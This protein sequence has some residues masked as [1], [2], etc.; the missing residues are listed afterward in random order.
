MFC[1]NCGKEIPEEGEFC[2]QCGISTEESRKLFKARLEEAAPAAPSPSIDFPPPGQSASA[3]YA[4]IQTKQMETLPGQSSG[5][6]SEAPPPSPH[7]APKP[8]TF[9]VPPSGQPS[10]QVSETPPP[11]PFGAPPSPNGT[12][13]SPYDAPQPAPIGAAP[14]M[15]MGAAPTMPMSTAPSGP[16]VPVPPQNG[17]PPYPPQ[18]M[19]AP[20][21]PKKKSKK[22]IFI[23]I[24]SVVLVALIVVGVIVGINIYRSNSYDNAVAMLESG[25][26]QGAYDAFGKLGDYEDSADLQALAQR[27]MDY[28]AAVALF[29]A[30]D[31]E[32][33][34]TAFNNLGSFEDS[35]DYVELCTL[36][37]DYKAAVATYNRGDYETALNMFKSLS[38]KNFLDSSNWVDKSKYAIATEKYESG[39]LYGAYKD[40]KALGSFD[41]S[42]E[43]MEKCTTPYP[44]T[45]ELYHNPS[46][47]S[48]RSAI[49]LD[50]SNLSRVSYYKVY[51]GDTLVSTI[52][53]NPGG[54]VTIEVP[55]GT[56]T[57][58][59]AF[60]SAW[61]GEEILFGD[62]GIYSVMLI[63]NST[64]F[65]LADNII[66]TITMAVTEGNIGSDIVGRQGF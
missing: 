10:G 61:F 8:S 58:K 4:A 24:G 57:I 1:T 12:P 48:S 27:W 28:K 34:L 5:Q 60:G 9:E 40:F 22:G 25:D 16:M 43:M 33:A 44:A 20:V 47:V 21:K 41:D 7:E 66:A 46:Y 29:N 36:N 39:D 64:S 6:V 35:S 56:Y 38:S 42:S 18:G 65:D 14:T 32:A 50:A 54:K 3:F 31:F 13:P 51:S 49:A 17:I 53:I 19:P 52:W 26:Y 59:E 11:S 2:P 63:N 37:I 15:P 23:A 55:P 62:E 30:N 45:G